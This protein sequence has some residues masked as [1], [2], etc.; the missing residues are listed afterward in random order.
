[1][2]ENR[3]RMYRLERSYQNL[4]KRQETFEEFAKATIKRLDENISEIREQ[5]R[6]LY[7]K[8]DNTMKHIQNLT[9]GIAVGIG[10]IF[11]AIIALLVK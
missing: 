8:Y 6:Q 1:M 4:D 10:A 9:V 5:I 7:A 2:A 3:R 11:A